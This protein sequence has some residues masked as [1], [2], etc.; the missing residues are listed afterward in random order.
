MN[1]VAVS[2]A[3]FHLRLTSIRARSLGGCVD[4]L[5]QCL[6]REMRTP[7]DRL[8]LTVAQ[9]LGDLRQEP[10]GVD[11]IAGHTVPQV[12][13]PHVGQTGGDPGIVPS[14]VFLDMWLPDHR[15]WQKM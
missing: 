8:Q 2:P 15:F 9:H 14:P 6:L 10:S 7:L 13:Y 12:M 1:R 5:Q 4:R 3:L 11:H